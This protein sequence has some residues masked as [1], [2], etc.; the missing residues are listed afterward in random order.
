MG[1]IGAK[2]GDDGLDEADGVLAGGGVDG[3]GLD[4][5]VVEVGFGLF[6]AFEE[7]FEL[8]VDLLGFFAVVVG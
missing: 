6:D 1:F 2:V 3:D 5:F 8:G 4:E 7:F